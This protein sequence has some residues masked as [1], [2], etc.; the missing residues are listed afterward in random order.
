MHATVHARGIVD[1]DTTHH[2]RAYR[3][4]VWGE[5]PSVGFQNLIH[6]RPHNTRLQFYAFL[7]SNYLITFP[8]FAR[9]DEHGIR[10]TL[11]A[12]R[13]T[14]RTE[15][16]GHLVFPAQLHNLRDFRLAIATDDDLGDLAIETSIR[17]PTEGTEFIGI[18][19]VRRQHLSE[20]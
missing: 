12:Q 5:Y 18:D 9:H 15:S 14:C 11:S 10:T 16:K 2:R 20:V 19:T 17:S 13:C 7:I 3:S 6:P 4:R 8:V 1:D